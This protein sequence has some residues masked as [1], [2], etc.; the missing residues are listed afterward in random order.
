MRL[1]SVELDE[2]TP[3]QLKIMSLSGNGNAASFF[4]QNGVRD[5]HIK[6][7]QKYNSGAARQYRA[8]LKKLLASEPALPFEDGEIKNTS[9]APSSAETDLESILKG[10]KGGVSPLGSPRSSYVEKVPS[11][12]PAKSGGEAVN[13]PRSV[14]ALFDVHLCSAMARRHFSSFFV[15]AVFSSNGESDFGA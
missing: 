12:L 3:E 9:A 6:T 7:E 10:L 13:I 2:W 11:Q 4:R 15:V 14:V 8:H 5:M 1:S